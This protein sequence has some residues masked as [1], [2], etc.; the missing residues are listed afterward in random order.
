MVCTKPLNY[1]ELSVY[2]V[3]RNVFSLFQDTE[4]SAL[5]RSK[6]KL[7]RMDGCRFICFLNLRQI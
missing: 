6:R 5:V 2:L 3:V 4:E 1:V 7:P